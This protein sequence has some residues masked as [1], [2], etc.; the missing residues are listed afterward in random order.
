MLLGVSGSVSLMG[1]IKTFFFFCSIFFSARLPGR[2]LDYHG[3]PNDFL[4]VYTY[5]VYSADQ[6]N[7]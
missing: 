6:H 2:I 1:T 3:Y 5:T 4:T 7:A